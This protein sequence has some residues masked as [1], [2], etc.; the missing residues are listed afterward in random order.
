MRILSWFLRFLSWF[1][2][3]VVHA[4]AWPFGQLLR[5]SRRHREVSRKNLSL[6]YPHLTE[7]ERE[8]LVVRSLNEFAKSVLEAGPGWYWPVDTVLAKM[9]EIHGREYLEQALAA[10]NGVILAAPHFGAWEWGSILLST[11]TPDDILYLYKPSSNPAVDEFINSKRQRSGAVTVP[12]NTRGLRSL[13]RA[14]RE[15]KTV[16]ILP[17]QQPKKGD[18]VFAPFFGVE[19]LTQTLI[20][21]LAQRAGCAVVFACIQRLPAGKGFELHFLPAPGEIYSTSQDE[22]LAAL[23]KGVENCIA[24]DP[25]QYLWAYKRFGLRPGDEPRFY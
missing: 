7:R 12:A 8:R 18:G 6:C 20:P 16:A 2:L 14:L 3:P 23:N 21:S 25:G 19:A 4:I 1:P 10:G 15:N 11:L 17:D 13:L 24:I 5:L 22:A 9:K